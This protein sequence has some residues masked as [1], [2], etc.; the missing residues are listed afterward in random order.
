MMYQDLTYNSFQVPKYFKTAKENN[1]VLL[2]E[3]LSPTSLMK[4]RS[5][6]SIILFGTSKGSKGVARWAWAPPVFS[7]PS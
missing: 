7:R 3:I 4:C 6:I 1:I 2:S 5:F